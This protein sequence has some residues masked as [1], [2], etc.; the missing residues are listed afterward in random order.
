MV[1]AHVFD[2]RGYLAGRDDD[3]LKDINDAI[4]DPDVRAIIATRG[5][6]GAYRIAAD[7]DFTSLTRD[8]K[9]LVGFSEIT[10]LHLEIL[11]ECGIA[12]LHGAAWPASFEASSSASFVRA[13]MTSEMIRTASVATESTAALTTSGRA[14]GPLI[15]GNQELL[16]TSAGWAV[17]D[18][19]GAI[20]LLEA[21][22]QGLG[23]MDRDLTMLINSG[24]LDRVVGVAVGQFTDCG[25]DETTQGDW[26]AI[27]VLRD[28]LSLLG[29]PVLGGLPIGHGEAPIAVPVGTT[30]T[31]DAD[32][33]TLTVES[34]VY[35]A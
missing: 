26:T 11:K 28:R 2:R 19:T 20:L 13:A 4:R 9:L 24:A 23:Q 35:S 10:I 29:V 8:P 12:G 15:G 18:L 34:C 33:G 14:N 25:P 27:D 1:G 3:R 32:S 16:A 17:P 31:L 5:G 7:I 6:K 30:A 21:F 22:G